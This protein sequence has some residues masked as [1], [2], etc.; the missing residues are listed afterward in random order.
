MSDTACKVPC[1]IYVLEQTLQRALATY[2]ELMDWIIAPLPL[3]MVMVAG[4]KEEICWY[5]SLATFAERP[6]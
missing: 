5:P 3:Q 1:A 4:P 6:P 2:T